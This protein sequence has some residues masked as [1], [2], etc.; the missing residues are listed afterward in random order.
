MKYKIT[1]DYTSSI[2][3]YEKG[4]EV[5][6]DDELAEFLERDSPGILKPVAEK[7]KAP[8]KTEDETTKERAPQGPPADR[9]AKG[10]TKRS[11]ENPA[12]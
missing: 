7:K 1:H 8:A 5:D 9:A 11:P 2:G 3:S 4:A 12:E 10:T 6:L